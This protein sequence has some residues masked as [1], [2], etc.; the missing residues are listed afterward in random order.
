MEQISEAAA[1]KKPGGARLKKSSKKPV[2]VAFCVILVA[3]AAAYLGLCAY[4]NALDTF[5]PNFRINGVEV[6]GLTVEE[7]QETLNTELP[8]QIVTM[9]A[10]EGG[11]PVLTVSLSELG[12][13]PEMVNETCAVSYEDWAETALKDLSD[14]KFFAKGWDFL[15]YALSRLDGVHY[16]YLF[17]GKAFEAAVDRIKEQLTLPYLDGSYTLGEDSISIT[18]AR[19]G[20][21]VARQALVEELQ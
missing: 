14:G 17:T 8:G 2:I 18:K 11:E 21:Y 3:L 6:S 4:V 1:Q 9:T 10:S 7:A 16:G 12:F 20:Y 13:S 5:Y 15:Q 19:D